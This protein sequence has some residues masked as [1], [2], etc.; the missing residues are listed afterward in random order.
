MMPRK[1][2]IVR[3]RQMGM[4]VASDQERLMLVERKLRS[5]MGSFDDFQEKLHGAVRTQKHGRGK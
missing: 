5:G 1:M 4:L 3:K 2:L